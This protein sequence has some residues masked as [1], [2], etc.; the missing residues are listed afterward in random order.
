MRNYLYIIALGIIMP[1]FSSA[2]TKLRIAVIGSSTAAGTGASPA[3]SSWVNRFKAYC[4]SLGRLDSLDNRALGGT[5]TF[6]GLPGAADTTRNITHAV[7]FNPDIVLISYPTND[8]V[9]DIPLSTYLA[10]LRTMYNI[11]VAAGKKCYVCSTQPRNLSNHGQQLTLQ[12]GKDSILA[13]FPG[14]SFDFFDPLVAPSSLDINP[15]YTPDGIHP[16][17]AGH[18]LL[19]QVVLSANILPPIPPL[20]L[21]FE[22][23]AGHRTKQGIELDWKAAAQGSTE[24]FIVQRSEDGSP[25]RDIDDQKAVPSAPAQ[26]YSFTDKVPLATRAFYRLKIVVDG[27]PAFSN[28][29]LFDPDHKKFGIQRFYTR[30]GYSSVNA[31]ISLP[32]DQVILLT[33]LSATGR[34]VKQQSY[35]CRAPSAMLTAYLPPL[36][37]GVY[38]LKISTADGDQ[39]VQSFAFRP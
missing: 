30:D 29:V 5:T 31:E 38:F 28:V 20:A 37:A 39:I 11:V 14:H 8:A 17:N 27:T 22:S 18:R 32:K 23:F 16:N 21:L 35:T 13:E 25:Y 10:N 1:I 2:Q 7:N 12:I 36:A 33:I 6:N 3:D 4:K 19:Y 9:A 24:D 34:P 26:E 15:I